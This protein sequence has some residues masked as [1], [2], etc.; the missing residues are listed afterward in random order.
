MIRHRRHHAYRASLLIA[1]LPERSGARDGERPRPRRRGEPLEERAPH[2][3][4]RP[5]DRRAEER[6]VAGFLPQT[7]ASSTAHQA[8]P[9]FSRL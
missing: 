7:S 6:C 4:L 3:A 8:A 2:A 1:P 5:D 9:R